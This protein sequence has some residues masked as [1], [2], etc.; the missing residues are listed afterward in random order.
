MRGT[1]DRDRYGQEVAR[2]REKIATLDGP[3]WR[4]FL[5]AWHEHV[6]PA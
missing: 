2:A 3:H 4:E 5:A 6:E 1:L